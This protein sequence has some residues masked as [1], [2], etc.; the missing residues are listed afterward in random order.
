MV[1]RSRTRT[2]LCLWLSL[3]R[4][5][6]STR[7]VAPRRRLLFA[8]KQFSEV[9]VFLVANTVPSI[10][11]KHA[12]S[13]RASGDIRRVPLSHLFLEVLASPASTRPVR[14]Y[15][16]VCVVTDGVLVGTSDT[17]PVLLG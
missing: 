17:V 1:R 7:D 15:V 4:L 3:S 16:P 6:R 11:I 2:P 9:D 12:T 8:R 5:L 13:P 10:V 14:E